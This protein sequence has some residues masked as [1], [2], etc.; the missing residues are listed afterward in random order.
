M[1][2]RVCPGLGCQVQGQEA[3]I[4]KKVRAAGMG[5]RFQ[6]GEEATHM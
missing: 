6:G 4:N 5:K 3:F 2:L 1:L